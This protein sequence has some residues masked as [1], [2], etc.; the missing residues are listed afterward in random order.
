MQSPV[1]DDKPAEVCTLTIPFLKSL[2]IIEQGKVLYIGK[3]PASI[4]MRKMGTAMGR[5]LN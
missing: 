1:P 2:E 5:Q 3:R 4:V